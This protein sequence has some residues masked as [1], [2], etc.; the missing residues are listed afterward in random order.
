MRR[1]ACDVGSL[2]DEINQNVMSKE[3][4]AHVVV[5]DRT[6]QLSDDEVIQEFGRSVTTIMMV[7]SRNACRVS[8]F[9]KNVNQKLAEKGKVV[10]ELHDE[11]TVELQRSFLTELSHEECI[12]VVVASSDEVQRPTLKSLAEEFDGDVWE[13]SLY[14]AVNRISDEVDIKKKLKHCKNP[15]ERLQLERDLNFVTAN[16]GFR[17][18]SK[19]KYRK[20]K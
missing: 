15:M 12:E 13:Y 18:S 11:L 6:Q 9:I 10:S 20:K 5:G 3:C 19:K 16:K 8:D 2:I 1:E 4:V 17:K 14:D 7:Q